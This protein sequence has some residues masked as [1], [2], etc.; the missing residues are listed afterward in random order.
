MDKIKHFV[1]CAFLTFVGFLLTGNLIIGAILG[2][3]A[4][5]G[6]EIYDEL[7]GT[8]FDGLDLVADVLGIGVSIFFLSFLF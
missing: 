4:G 1:G 6:K 7:Y 3:M 5:L 2:L 8:G